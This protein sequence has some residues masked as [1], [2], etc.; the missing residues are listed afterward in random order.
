MH[1]VP[2]LFK[3]LLSSGGHAGLED[4]GF[5]D[6]RILQKEKENLWTH[7]VNRKILRDPLLWNMLIHLGACDQ[8]K[9]SAKPRLLPAARSS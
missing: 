7:L 6:R 2:L 8:S 3:Y 4:D 5:T 1:H 9:E